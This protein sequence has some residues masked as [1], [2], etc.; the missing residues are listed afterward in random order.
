VARAEMAFAVLAYN[1]KR[2]INVV[3]ARQMIALMDG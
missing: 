2:A 1:L 3:D